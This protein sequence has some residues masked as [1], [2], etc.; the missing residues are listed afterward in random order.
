[1]KPEIV[2]FSL[3]KEAVPGGWPGMAAPRSGR[4]TGGLVFLQRSCC[5]R[6]GSGGHLQDGAEEGGEVGRGQEEV[7]R[8]H[9]RTVTELTP[10]TSPGCRRDGCC[11]WSRCRSSGGWSSWL[12]P[13]ASSA[14]SSEKGREHERPSGQSTA[15][16]PWP[17][18]SS[19]LLRQTHL[20]TA[21]HT[22]SG[23]GF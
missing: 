23:P 16:P 20:G 13:A 22:G 18:V 21:A 10:G 6:A 19:R 1:M 12:P 9:G 5:G 8:L 17:P 3:W 14:C 7:G 11:C 2:Q 4:R 15:R